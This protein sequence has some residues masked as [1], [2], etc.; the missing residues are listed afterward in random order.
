[1]FFNDDDQTLAKIMDLAC[2]CG[3]GAFEI[4]SESMYFITNL[5]TSA[6]E[7]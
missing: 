7:E 5:I 6:S 1:V 4:F 3:S 2:K